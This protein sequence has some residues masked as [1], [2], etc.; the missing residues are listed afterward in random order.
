MQFCSQSCASTH[1]AENENCLV[2]AVGFQLPAAAVGVD[3]LHAYL[4]AVV[5]A[6]H[7]LLVLANS[8]LTRKQWV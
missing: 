7:W 5:A 8:C 1:V 2:A 3:R 4:P 6:E